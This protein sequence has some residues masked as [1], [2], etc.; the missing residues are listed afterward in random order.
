[1]DDLIGRDYVPQ[2]YFRTLTKNE[3]EDMLLRKVPLH[4]CIVFN[5]DSV[6]KGDKGD[7]G[8]WMVC[9]EHHGKFMKAA[10]IQRENGFSEL[11]VDETCRKLKFWTKRATGIEEISL[12]EL[13]R[14]EPR[15]G[16]I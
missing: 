5:C 7:K 8:D 6:R 11:F 4:L 16:V 9:E 15:K 2:P 12:E 14:R 13:V 10:D 1:M 3:I